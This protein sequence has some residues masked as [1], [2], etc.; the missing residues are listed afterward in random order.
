[1]SYLGAGA[2]WRKRNYL[3]EPDDG[4][5][6]NNTGDVM[7]VT[8][9]AFDAVA[10]AGIIDFTEV[11]LLTA[12]PL[13][14]AAMYG[15]P[16]DVQAGPCFLAQAYQT[17]FD[18]DGIGY[19]KGTITAPLTVNTSG[20]PGI[21]RTV[22]DGAWNPPF[23]PPRVLAGDADFTLG[24]PF[25]IGFSE[26]VIGVKF[27]L[28]GF[29][30]TRS[31]RVR[32]YDRDGN[33]L[34]EGTNTEPDPVTPSDHKTFETFCIARDSSVAIIAGVSIEISA[35]ESNGVA[36]KNIQFCGSCVNAPEVPTGFIYFLDAEA[37]FD[38]YG[39]GVQ[40]VPILLDSSPSVINADLVVVPD[41]EQASVISSTQIRGADSTLNKFSWY[42]SPPST[43]A[44]AFNGASLFVRGIF[45]QA[46]S[47][48]QFVLADNESVTT[49]SL[50]VAVT[51]DVTVL[52]TT[53]D[54][55]GA[56]S[57]FVSPGSF[58]NSFVEI[59]I[60]PGSGGT[61]QLF[62]NG[63]ELSA[64]PSA[65]TEMPD[66]IPTRIMSMIIIQNPLDDD[67]VKHV[68]CWPRVLTESERS[69]L[70]LWAVNQ[71]QDSLL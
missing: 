50:S 71:S 60:P 30:T 13:I 18:P 45:Q 70:R 14:T 63:V 61:P 40:N 6:C 43:E 21:A 59:Y 5:T 47:Y 62:E 31:V 8:E 58:S 12:N 33:L 32:A 44:I 20:S 46:G 49:Q 64:I 2:D 68:I 48:V 38:A 53:R 19:L 15:G 10:L 39:I 55:V 28:G 23:D 22:T 16:V 57:A 42:T 41:N 51:A 25:V 65:P 66:V 35:S 67:M 1:M 56:T 3:I 26:D 36:L 29:N 17:I 24:L 37:Q 54:S 11:A 69:Q 9:E 52:S 7:R 4:P 27:T 34:W